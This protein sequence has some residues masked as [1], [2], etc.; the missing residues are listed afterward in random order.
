MCS[1]WDN[2]VFSSC[3]KSL[4]K[5]K[6]AFTRKAHVPGGDTQANSQ[7]WKPGSPSTDTQ[8]WD[9]QF[10]CAPHEHQHGNYNF[11][12]R[13]P[14]SFHSIWWKIKCFPSNRCKIYL[15]VFLLKHNL[16]KDSS[17]N[18]KTSQIIIISTTRDNSAFGLVLNRLFVNYLKLQKF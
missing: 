10:V 11:C 5:G 4:Y 12:S 6:H 17:V 3:F 7:P 18:S 9:P 14:S 8:A 16:Q 1:N 13:Q 15:H 2:T